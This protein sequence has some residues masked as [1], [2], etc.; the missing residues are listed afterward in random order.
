[1]IETKTITAHRG[2]KNHDAEPIIKF[3]VDNSDNACEFTLRTIHAHYVLSTIILKNE[4]VSGWEHQN[5]MILNLFKKLHAK[6]RK[7]P[8]REKSRLK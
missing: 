1:M 3:L 7:K 6:K 4:G 8:K 2:K 5:K